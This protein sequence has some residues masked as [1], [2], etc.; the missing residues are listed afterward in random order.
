MFN[1]IVSLFFKLLEQKQAMDILRIWNWAQSQPVS[2]YFYFKSW[3]C[4]GFFVHPTPALQNFIL[5]PPPFTKVLV[6]LLEIYIY[7]VCMSVRIFVSNKRQ[8]GWT[9]RSSH[10]PR[11]GL[12]MIKIPKLCLNK[13]RFSLNLKIH[14]FF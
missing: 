14:E 1:L 3:N 6:A 11:K 8:I 13:I 12:W 2:I 9:D 10:D 7:I 5:P 4:S